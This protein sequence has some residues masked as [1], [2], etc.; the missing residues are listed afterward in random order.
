MIPHDCIVRH[1]PPD[2]YGDCLRAAIASILDIDKTTDVPHFLRDG[3]DE[4]GL[5]ELRTWLLLEHRLRPFAMV[6]DG[7]ASLDDVFATMKNGNPD[8]DYL[9]FCQCGSGDHVVVCCNDRMTH[10]PG[11]DNAAI[12]GPLSNGSWLVMVM[13]RA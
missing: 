11:W 4:R 8:V 10:N 6:F 1:N 9:L 2:T 3:D 7:S 13:V 12:S 5:V